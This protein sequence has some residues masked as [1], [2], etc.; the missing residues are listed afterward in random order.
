MVTV[1]PTESRATAVS[2]AL[3]PTAIVGWEDDTK[4]LAMRTGRS[5][6]AIAASGSERS[7]DE[8]V[9]MRRSIVVDEE[10]FKL[11]TI[12]RAKTL[13]EPGA[14]RDAACHR[15]EHVTGHVPLMDPFTS[16]SSPRETQCE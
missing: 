1:L 7:A 4:M 11:S 6:A 3:S 9:T 8:C 2:C 15:T 16:Q 13:A 10:K 12:E 14:R 5:T